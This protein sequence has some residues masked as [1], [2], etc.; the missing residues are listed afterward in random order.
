MNNIIPIRR[1][2]GEQTESGRATGAGSDVNGKGLVEWPESAL[3]YV[4][5]R[6][7]WADRLK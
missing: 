2:Q 1:G 7:T 5:A 6:S 4:L 3:W